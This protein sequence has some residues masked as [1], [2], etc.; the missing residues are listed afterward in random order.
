MARRLTTVYTCTA[1]AVPLLLVFNSPALFRL[2]S[3]S[4]EQ[5][6][7]PPPPPKSLNLLYPSGMRL[8]N[9]MDFK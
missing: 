8:L 9:L 4:G 2:P 7:L 5:Q 3:S 6:P 1:L